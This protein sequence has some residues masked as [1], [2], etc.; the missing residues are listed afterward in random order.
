MDRS[1][2]GIDAAVGAAQSSEVAI[3][4]VGGSGMTTYGIGW[5]KQTDQQQVTSGEGFDV[6]DLG[7][8]GIQQRLVE[9]VIATGTPTVVLLIGGRPLS[10]PWIARNAPALLAVWCPGQEGGYAI[11]DI[12][13]GKESPSGKLPVSIPSSVGQVPLFHSHKPS[14]GGIYHTPGSLDAPGRDYVFDS[15]EPLYPFGYGLSYTTFDY[16]GLRIQP[17][18]IAPDGSVTVE[19]DVRN[20]G[21]RAGCETVQCYVRDLVSSTTTPVQSL[22]AFRRV[23]LAPG[24]SRTLTFVL[25]PDDLSLYDVNLNR[26]VEPG[27]FEARIGRLRQTFRLQHGSELEHKCLTP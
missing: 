11:A 5:G 25:T 19:V 14:A 13:F 23:D 9:E 2:S 22:C 17:G 7:L 10:L 26:I 1:S 8:P 24:E 12:L 6:T 16:S 15:P 18:G 20:T 27:E 3:L 21:E 4:C